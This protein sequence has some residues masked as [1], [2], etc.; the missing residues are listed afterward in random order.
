MLSSSL[1]SSMPASVIK[2][3]LW[4]CFTLSAA[5]AA[6]AQVA[7]DSR[8]SNSSLA[9]GWDYDF[10]LFQML[11]EEQG[12][13]T[14]GWQEAWQSPRESV[15]VIAGEIRAL[16]LA[17]RQA[18]I[19]FVDSG[20]RLLLATDR[21]FSASGIGTV[22]PGPVIA[23]RSEYQYQG[24]DDCLRLPP[25]SQQQVLGDVQQ[26]ILNRSGWF[27]TN[28][29]RLSWE[30]L[31]ALP[32][33]CWPYSS[34]LQPAVAVG[35]MDEEGLVVVSADASLFTNG[36][37]WHGDNAV[38]AIRIADLLCSGVSSSDM[39]SE[40]QPDEPSAGP[41]SRLAFLR[42]GQILNSFRDRLPRS[43]GTPPPPLPEPTLQ[44]MLRL[45]NAITKE[46]EASNLLNETLMRQPRRLAA[47][48]YFQF[49][50]FVLAVAL[51]IGA[52]LF[53]L[54]GG[55]FAN[56]FFKP[57]NMRAAFEMRESDGQDYRVPAAYLAREFCRELTGSGNSADW[58]QFRSRLQQQDHSN[59]DDQ[60]LLR[61]AEVMD[62]ASR[63]CGRGFGKTDFQLLGAKLAKLR[64]KHLPPQL[65]G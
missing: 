11:L 31:V 4:T 48:R 62:I 19:Q 34:R 20:G 47:Y 44:R 23:T 21:Q 8:S 22:Q 13:R 45:A 65:S 35:R 55:S 7:E 30:T 9:G 59:F 29:D 50:L 28:T 6:C 25:T 46:V 26:V 17:T 3:L 12:L 36:M 61:L 49:L 27:R 14:V 2:L 52:L 18:L 64:A 54:F 40:R 32:K 60:D 16:P 53:V 56:R 63:G 41:R 24:F 15:I 37:L 5:S 43:S 58:H 51:L 33:N 1:S 39:Y 10:D 57:R 42:D 38:L